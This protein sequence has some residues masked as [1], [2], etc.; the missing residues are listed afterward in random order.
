M[1]GSAEANERCHYAPQEASNGDDMCSVIF[2]TKNATNGRCCSLYAE[3]CET[4][5]LQTQA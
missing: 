2:V 1:K 4:D 3:V 5:H